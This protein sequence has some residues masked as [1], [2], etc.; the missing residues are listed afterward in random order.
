MKIILK[1]LEIFWKTF[2]KI[3][4]KYFK[5]ISPKAIIKTIKK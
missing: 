3:F 1:K 4:K 2:S 5:N